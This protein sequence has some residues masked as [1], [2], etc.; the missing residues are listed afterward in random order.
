M[1][2]TIIGSGNMAKGIGSRLLSGGHDVTLHARDND[3]VTAITSELQSA[4]AKGQI[5]SVAIGSPADDIVILATPYTEVQNIAKNYDNFKN[6]IVVDITNP[7]DFNTFQLI[8]E[9]GRS[10]AQ[11]IADSLPAATIVKA[12]NI[13]LAGALL[14]GSIEKKSW[15]SL[16]QATTSRLKQR[17][18]SW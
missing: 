3:K 2:V 12:F 1:Q 14:A 16:L 17:F 7:V 10:G 8:P 5:T 13:N 11:E 15:M 18:G 4:E 6:K 9:A